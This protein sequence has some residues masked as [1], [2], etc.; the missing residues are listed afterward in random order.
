MGTPESARVAQTYFDSWRAHDFDTLRTILADDVTFQGPL[1]EV[2]GADAY[3]D[4]LARLGKITKDIV[5]R[6]VFVDGPDVLTWFDLHTEVAPP[7]PVANWCHVEDGKIT[8]V[9]VTFDP[10][11]LAP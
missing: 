5:V 2:E 8:R 3:R 1:A 6:R 11:G 10:R 7:T 4:S 9:Q